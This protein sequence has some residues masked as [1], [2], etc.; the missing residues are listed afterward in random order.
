MKLIPNLHIIAYDIPN[1]KRRNKLIKCLTAY[2]TRVQYSVF[3]ATLSDGDVKKLW[4]EIQKV[5]KEEDS[6]FIYP[7]PVSVQKCILKSKGAEYHLEEFF[8][9]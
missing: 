5:I 7:V 8:I 1:N 9:S 2:G 4:K 3:E 6:V